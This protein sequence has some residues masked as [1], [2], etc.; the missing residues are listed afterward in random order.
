MKLIVLLFTTLI[1]NSCGSQKDMVA[2]TNA[3]AQQVTTATANKIQEGTSITYIAQ[4]RGVFKEYKIANNSISSITKRGG[5]AEVKSCTKSEVEA[6]NKAMSSL[7][8]EQLPSLEAPSTYRYSD[9]AAIANL[10]VVKDGKTYKSAA[11][12]DGNPPA[13]LKTLVDLVLNI[14]KGDKSQKE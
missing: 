13:E 1:A 7:V 11:F 10:I 12:D 6:V 3:T 4:T 5:T 9:G 2:D 8:L 14:A